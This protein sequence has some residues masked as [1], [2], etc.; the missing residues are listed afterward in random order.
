MP[1]P[2]E[3]A[4]AA[5]NKMRAENGDNAVFPSD[6]IW[7]Y[8]DSPVPSA[9]RPG[10]IGWLHRN[11]HIARTGNMC[12]AATPARAGSMTPEYRFVR[13]DNHTEPVLQLLCG[14]F[15]D[16]CEG[17]LAIGKPVIT[18]FVSA[19]LCKR[20]LILSG[21]SGSGKT[22]V[23][24]AFARWLTP[25]AAHTDPFSPG[26]KIQSD[27]ITYHVKAADRLSVEFWN[28]PDE[29]KAIKVALPRA[30]ITEWA[31]HIQRNGIKED[32]GAQ[33]LREAVETQS[34]F[35]PYLHGFE[36]HLKAAA[37]ALLRSRHG[38]Q[39]VKCYE[40][41]PVGADWTG[42]ENILGYPNGLDATTYVS[43]PTLALIQQAEANKQIPHFLILDEMN[44]SHVERYFADLL[45][46]VESGEEIPLYEGSTRSANGKDV[47]RRLCI[48]QNLFIIG[49]VNVDE[50]TYMFSPKVLDRAGVIEFRMDQ[51]DLEAFLGDP[52]AP[53]LKELD[54]KGAKFAT[55]FVTA[56]TDTSVG[57]PPKVRPQYEQEMVL[58]FK[59]LQRHNAEYG[60]RVAYEAAR[61]LHFYKTLG[62]YEDNDTAWFLPA[63]DALVVQKFLPK[64]HGSQAKLGKLLKALWFLATTSRPYSEDEEQN[65]K[66]VADALDHAAKAS[67]SCDV[68]TAPS[69][70]IP[71]NA[72]YPMSADKIHRMWYSLKENGFASFAE[73]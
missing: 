3:I 62:G 18:R 12:H 43:K 44:L 57:I 41:V 52:K 73:A 19:L 13:P 40:V 61:F 49:T 6:E 72:P 39:S 9:R 32:I 10:A 33:T 51:E 25:T 27:R 24:Q 55:A 15:Q 69:A 4:L 38:P 26:A 28:D 22:K 56:A 11:R 20:F 71:T 64:L 63:T 36:T 45:S 23:A 68:A 21:L 50:T 66:I 1:E 5:L 47:P 16:D 34:K 31:D 8:A 17:V 60:Y 14:E 2:H 35:S 37:F 42:N 30:M 54:G 65:A 53:D 48:P 29:Q 59:L 70:A 67:S 46:A 58:F 7:N